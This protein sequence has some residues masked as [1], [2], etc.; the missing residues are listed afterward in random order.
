MAVDADFAVVCRPSPFF[1]EVELVAF[2]TV[3]LWLVTWLTIFCAP[4]WLDII[5]QV[6]PLLDTVPRTFGVLMSAPKI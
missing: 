3:I 4:L 2:G 1:C 5:R 6:E